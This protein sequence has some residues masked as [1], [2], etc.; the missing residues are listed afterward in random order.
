MAQRTYLLSELVNE[1][2]YLEN[3]EHQKLKFTSLEQNEERFIL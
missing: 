2:N 1:D 3:K